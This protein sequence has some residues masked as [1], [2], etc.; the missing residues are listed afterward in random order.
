MIIIQSF[1]Y[2]S[3]RYSYKKIITNAIFADN[4]TKFANNFQIAILKKK[5]LM[6][7][8]LMHEQLNI[9]GNNTIKVKWDDFPHFTFPWHYHNQYEIVYVL[10]SYGRRYVGDNI[11][12]FAEGDLVLLGSNLP[13]YWKNAPEFYENNPKLKVNAVVVQFSPELFGGNMLQLPE[14]TAMKTLL[15]NA[16][17]GIKFSGL[18]NKTI[19]KKLL[20]ILQLTG[21]ERYIELLNILNEM[22]KHTQHEVL[23]STHFEKNTTNYSDNRL[24]KIFTYINYNYTAK[25]DIPSLANL[26]GM[27]VTALCRFFKSKTG[28]TIMQHINELRVGYACKLMTEKQLQIAQIATECGFNNLSNFNKTFKQYTSKTPTTYYELTKE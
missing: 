9:I 10:K 27:N 1:K 25:I 7:M 24:N 6:Y 17:R 21:F 16:E 19:C 8:K 2:Q 15:N 23:A 12:N 4:N 20:K 18:Q 5:Y 14:F 22:S 13:H 26:S 11:E 28:K 3:Q